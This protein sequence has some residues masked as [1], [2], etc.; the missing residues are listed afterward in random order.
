MQEI[1]RK[2]IKEV[3]G[4][5]VNHPYSGHNVFYLFL[6][7]M[8]IALPT[9]MLFT[10]SMTANSI[11]GQYTG[12]DALIIAFKVIFSGGSGINPSETNAVI[13]H[14][15]DLNNAVM[16][17]GI[18]ILVYIQAGLVVASILMSV[19]AF[20]YFFALLFRGYLKKSK[21]VKILS[22]F[23]LVFT[24]LFTL[25]FLS[26]FLMDLILNENTSFVVWYSFIPFGVGL[27]FFILVA[28]TYATCF[29]NTVLESDLEFHEDSDGQVVTEVRVNNVTK[30][31]EVA[32]N[33]LPRNISN[34]GGH[35]FSENQNLIVANIPLGISSLGAGAFANCLHLK[36]VSLPLSVKEIG[37]NCFFNCASLE[38]I[39]Y[40]GK[41]TDWK[42]IK[43]GSNWLSKAKTTEVVC[44]DGKIIVNPYR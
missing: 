27:I 6:V 12:L 36:V 10:P 42:K 7:L 23:D 15:F 41:K 22:G 34:I 35:A 2:K 37:F 4:F 16:E 28:A 33:S 9:C 14:V 26:F 18:Q 25:S 40:A 30:I 31:K 29:E 43:R 17:K 19:F 8:L 21:G 3:D 32:S 13:M 1:D 44:A 38:R 24:L 20:F 5:A 11:A 39:N